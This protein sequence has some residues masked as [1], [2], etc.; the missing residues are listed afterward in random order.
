MESTPDHLPGG[1]GQGN[2]RDPAPKQRTEISDE[3]TKRPSPEAIEAELARTSLRRGALE[4]AL[5][6]GDDNG[7]ESR[8]NSPQEQDDAALLREELKLVE[9]REAQ[10]LG[11]LNVNRDKRIRL[12][13]AL[14]PGDQ[15]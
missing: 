15:A 2:P 6:N 8:R 9:E 10:L 5:G 3:A 4:Q 12:E 11:A 1:N 14:H 13:A 7:N